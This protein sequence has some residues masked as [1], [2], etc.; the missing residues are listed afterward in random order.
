MKRSALLVFFLASTVS[1]QTERASKP[2]VATPS[3]GISGDALKAAPT[4]LHLNMPESLSLPP[5]AAI[6]VPS[7][8]LVAAPAAIS[9]T[10]E[11]EAR[12]GISART[13][14]LGGAEKFS[15]S[16]PPKGDAGREVFDGE[17]PAAPTESLAS[18]KTVKD[19]RHLPH[20]TAPTETPQPSI[21]LKQRL[22]ETVEMGGIALVW[23]LLSGLVF[24]IA[25]A[26]ASYP[27]LAGM[28][29]VMGGS[30]GIDYLAQLRSTIVGGWQASH[31]LRMR[32]DYST[33]QLKD[34]RG[35]KYGEDRYD[36]FAPGRVSERERL[37]VDG[38]AL[39][40]GLPWIWGAGPKAIALYAGSAALSIALRRLWR[41][42]RPKQK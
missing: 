29:W 41:L 35:R 11:V 28:L 42:R 4:P 16:P 21:P 33:G 18:A 15:Q 27:A 14:L 19:D 20:A 36:E 32:H 17:T 30:T 24:L 13:Q 6:A 5:A 34:I 1:A 38:T 3:I 7:A 12:P 10:E 22:G 40:L 37:V 8:E 23:Q 2:R 25:G 9:P 26:H 39:T 31:D